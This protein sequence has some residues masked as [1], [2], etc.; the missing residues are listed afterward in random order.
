MDIIS[1]NLHTFVIHDGERR[2]SLLNKNTQRRVQRCVGA[3]HCYVLE[4]PDVQVLYGLSQER[5]F[6]HL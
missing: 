3:D 1:T 6:W 4:C 2:H 5:G